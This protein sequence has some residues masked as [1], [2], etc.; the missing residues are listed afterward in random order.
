MRRL[1]ED[2]H[3]HAPA[4]EVYGRLR[5]FESHAEWL[6]PAFEE[7]A[8]DGETIAFALALPVRRERV[9]LE[10]ILAEA[11]QVLELADR[12]GGGW[13]LAWGLN[14]EGPREVH[15][16]AEIAYEPA[17]GAFGWVLEETMHRPMRRQALRDALWRLKLVVEGRR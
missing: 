5:Q 2:V 17:G 6:P 1:R 7:F 12:D 10:V 16:T 13:G 4:D 8:A 3:I 15:V 11:P 9:H 14:A